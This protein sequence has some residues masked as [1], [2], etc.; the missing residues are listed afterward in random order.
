MDVFII[1]DFLTE[2]TS[3]IPNARNISVCGESGPVDTTNHTSKTKEKTQLLC[4]WYAVFRLQVLVKYPDESYMLSP[5]Q[6][7]PEIVN[8]GDENIILNYH[9]L[10]FGF[11][12]AL[13]YTPAPRYYYFA[14]TVSCC[15]KYKVVALDW[16]GNVPNKFTLIL[17]LD[18]GFDILCLTM[19][20][21]QVNIHKRYAMEI[22]LKRTKVTC[23]MNH[24]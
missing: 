6:T 3:E 15:R 5:Y 23:Y 18:I 17:L 2:H 1:S 16:T 11:T 14:F 9:F 20:C 10:I 13:H 24:M 22:C 7:F 12:P 4:H 19:F 21:N 8:A